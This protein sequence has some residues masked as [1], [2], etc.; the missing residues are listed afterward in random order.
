MVLHFK[1]FMCTWNP[2]WIGVFSQEQTLTMPE[3]FLPSKANFWIS[4]SESSGSLFLSQLLTTRHGSWLCP[5]KK[6]P[7]LA[8]R[9]FFC[10]ILWSHEY[11]KCWFLQSWSD[12]A[13]KRQT[14]NQVGL[15]L[16]CSPQTSELLMQGLVWF[17]IQHCSGSWGYVQPEFVFRGRV[18]GGQCLM[19]ELFRCLCECTFLPPPGLPLWFD[20]LGFCS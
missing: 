8:A 13:A 7:V 1:H 4:S 15:I 16:V 20:Y 10:L 14:M 12:R 2:D 19:S 9:V 18:E 17:L 5:S 3:S 11:C 6:I